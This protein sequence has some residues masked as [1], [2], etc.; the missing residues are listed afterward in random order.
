MKTQAPEDLMMKYL[1]NELSPEE[2]RAFE[3]KFYDDEE[4]FAGLLAVEN[5]LV[6]SYVQGELKGEEK[7]RFEKRFLAT[8]EGRRK[9]ENAQALRQF[10]TD[11]KSTVETK[12]IAKRKNLLDILFPQS[13]AFQFAMMAA[14]VILAVGTAWLVYQRNS[15]RNQLQ[16]A[17][18]QPRIRELERELQEAQVLRKE[19]QKRLDE[20][21]GQSEQLSEQLRQETER[22]ELMERELAEARKRQPSILTALIAPGLSRGGAGPTR[23]A[24]PAGTEI[25]RLQLPLPS[26][27]GNFERYSASLNEA[28]GGQ[29]WS[30]KNIKPERTLTGKALTVRL[31]PRMLQKKSYVL[32]VR[33][34]T[35]EGQTEGIEAYPFNVVG[36]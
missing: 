28:S 36:P 19:L 31:S 33:G 6:D 29:V 9:V 1:L 35:A 11:R 26:D 4:I 7:T 24:I 15:L 14:V 2:Q 3:E 5:D 17:Q 20:Q 22:V 32:S 16:L 30:Q 12:G 10:I 34:Q 23:V 18:S 8:S 21:S 27:K 25:V 13:P